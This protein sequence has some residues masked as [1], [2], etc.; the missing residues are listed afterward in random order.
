MNEFRKEECS[1][2][3][4]EL[5]C[6]T[7]KILKIVEKTQKCTIKKERTRLM[8]DLSVKI[9]KIR[10]CVVAIDAPLHGGFIDIM[11]G[12]VRPWRPPEISPVWFGLVW[13]CQYGGSGSQGPLIRVCGVT[14][15]AHLRGSSNDTIGSRV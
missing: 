15:D 1:K 13:V 11:G 6:K 2:S 10:V 3:S 14:K 4:S 7:I 9:L 12:R 5:K 8:S